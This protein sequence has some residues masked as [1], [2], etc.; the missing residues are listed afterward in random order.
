MT[1][2]RTTA[3]PR[4]ARQAAWALDGAPNWRGHALCGPDVADRFT[5]GES[6]LTEANLTAL[7]MCRRCPVQRACTADAAATLPELRR[8]MIIGGVVYGRN[9]MPVPGRMPTRPTRALSVIDPVN[10][11]NEGEH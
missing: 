10:T 8:S 4:H 2:L 5:V 3:A 7:D 11:V 1:R 6:V 9:G